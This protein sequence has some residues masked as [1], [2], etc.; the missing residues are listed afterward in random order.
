MILFVVIACTYTWIMYSLRSQRWA[1]EFAKMY[2]RGEEMGYEVR[3]RVQTELRL[4][5]YVLVFIVT[6]SPDVLYR[7]YDWASG[8]DENFWIT[9]A[10]IVAGIQGFLN[11][12]VYC[13]SEGALRKFS[14][15][16]LRT[17]LSGK[18]PGEVQQLLPG[19][20][21]LAD[22]KPLQKAWGDVQQI[23][24]ETP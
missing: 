12:V 21:L 11:A 2:A 19:S 17:R 20:A 7:A 22:P 1:A 16:M 9:L 8:D 5:M 13:L 24:V 10:S 18:R 14:L 23:T 6:F 4:R 15:R 3:L